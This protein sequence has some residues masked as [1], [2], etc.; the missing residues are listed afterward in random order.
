MLGRIRHMKAP[1]YL[2]L[3]LFCISVFQILLKYYFSLYLLYSFYL[4]YIIRGVKSFGER[5]NLYK[6]P[7]QKLAESCDNRSISAY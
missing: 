3:K 1:P 7:N 2:L 6:N 5:L 4:N